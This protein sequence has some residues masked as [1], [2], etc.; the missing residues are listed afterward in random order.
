MTPELL[1]EM[2]SKLLSLLDVE[3]HSINIEGEH[4]T[5]V[6]VSSP[7]STKLIG[8]SGEHLK[9][10]NGIAR[11]L[12]EA[13]YGEEAASFLI[14]VNGYHE[15][16]MEAVRQNARMLAQRARL[17][18]HDVEMG[19]MSAYERLVVH[20]LFAGDPEITTESQGEGK[21]RHIVLKHKAA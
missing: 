21:F 7:D 9:A 14:D 2:V 11:R 4:R 1:K 6:A 5:V 8:P 16:Q 17:F 15:A 10:L 18:K 20:E 19:P 13:K 3:V 12:V